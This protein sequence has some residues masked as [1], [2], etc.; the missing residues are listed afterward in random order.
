MP[1]T[2]CQVRS[3]SLS[4]LC[5]L[6]ACAS[7][8]LGGCGGGNNGGG[9]TCSGASC[10]VSS[11][12]IT[13]ASANPATGVS[14]SYHLAQ[15]GSDPVSGT[16]PFTVTASSGSTMLFLAPPTAGN[17]NFSSWTG[18]TSVSTM[19]CTVTVSGNV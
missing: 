15:P 9:G 12:T 6:A 3:R 16:T 17:N 13:V 1:S 19:L 7:L 2:V 14:I 10:P 8:L 11:Y 4:A 5:L 18:C